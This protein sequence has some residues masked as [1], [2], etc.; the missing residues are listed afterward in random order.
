MP[1]AFR[2]GAE[3]ASLL[4]VPSAR[5]PA[6]GPGQPSTAHRFSR[7]TNGIA[8]ILCSTNKFFSLLKRQTAIMV[9]CGLVRLKIADVFPQGRENPQ[10]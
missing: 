3:P 6:G 4:A 8:S 7:R 1:S 5:F 10:G 2:V 9:R